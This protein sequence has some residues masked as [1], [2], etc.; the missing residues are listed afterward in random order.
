M[1]KLEIRYFSE[2]YPRLK[3]ERVGNWIDVYSNE[4]KELEPF[5]HYLIGLGFSIKL[6]AN[7]EA[8]LLPRSSSFKRWGF[9][10]ANSMGVIDETYCGSDDEWKLSIFSF[11]SKKI[12]RFDKIAQFRILKRMET[13][14][15]VEKD[16]L[17]QK[18]RGGFGST[19][20]R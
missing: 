3:V 19:G 13:L 18:S 1:E 20:R 7:Y 11:F 14:E 2:N 8:L 16:E 6:P 5:T 17:C 12:E 9:L 15:F 10:V 4:E